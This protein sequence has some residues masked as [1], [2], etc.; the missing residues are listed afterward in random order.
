MVV[1]IR[2]GG[3]IGTGIAWRLH[4]C[5][6][7]LIITEIPQPLAVRRKVSFCE[8]VYDGFTEVEGV[9]ATLV[10]AAEGAQAVWERGGIPL[11][12]DPECRTKSTLKPQ[13]LVDAVLAKRNL[14]TSIH[15]APL[16]IAVGPGFQ[17]G[18]DCHFV[19]ETNRGHH[20]GR[21]LLSGS[22]EPNTGIPGP[23]MGITEDR[24]LRAPAAGKW[25]SEMDIGAFVNP[26]DR[27]GTVQG[28]AVQAGIGGVIRGLIRQGVHVE[29]R[30]K[31]GD[32][33]PRGRQEYCNT[34][35]EKALAIAGGVLE[36]I[37]RFR[38]S[39]DH[40]PP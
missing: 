18:R 35:S 8:A 30:M 38:K 32:I 6:F 27:V 14:G 37:L 23:V 15:D 10:D 33:D 21:L 5:G 24:V 2:G 20:L 39:Q 22:A 29:P 7:Q 25:H 16:V 13:V 12:I 34:I 3:D 4:H 9:K 36:G 19:V 11:M 28:R 17:A 26:G 40:E 31:I 1:L